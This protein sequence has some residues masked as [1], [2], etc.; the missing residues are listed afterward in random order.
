MSP[1]PK[2]FRRLKEPPY[3]TGFIPENEDFDNNDYVNL[4]YE[5]FEALK[6]ADYDGLSQLEA[7]RQMEVSRPTFTRIYDSALKKIA[8]AL[9]EHKKLVIGGGNVVFNDKWFVCND[10]RTVF[11]EN[12]KQ[13]NNKSCPVCGSE[14]ITPLQNADL[15]AFNIRH[16]RHRGERFKDTGYCICPKCN[17]K[18]KHKRGIP[19]NSM[20]CPD[21]NIQMIREGSLHHLEIIEKLKN[22]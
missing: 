18:E 21:C 7:S 4:L 16:R 5:E 1:R 10:C 2:R 22:K 17:R 8:K 15:T 20:L 9:V 13:K 3:V 14:N 12:N 6:L 19:C 11:K